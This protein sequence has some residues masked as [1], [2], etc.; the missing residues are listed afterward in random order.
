MASST[1][2]LVITLISLAYLEE[3]GLLLL[4]GLLIAAVVLTVEL[5]AAREM[6]IAAKRMIGLW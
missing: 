5:V 4:I 3:D 6:V 2:A 1:P